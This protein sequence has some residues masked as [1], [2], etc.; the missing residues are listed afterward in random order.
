MARLNVVPFPVWSLTGVFPQPVE[1]A[2]FQNKTKTSFF[3]LRRGG[4]EPRSLAPLGMTFFS[5]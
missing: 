1:A 3:E 2:P 4:K 5:S